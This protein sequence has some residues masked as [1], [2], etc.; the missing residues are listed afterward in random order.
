MANEST[1]AAILAFVNDIWEAAVL[2]ARENSVMAPLVNS[3][4][5]RVGLADRF[6]SRYTG[7]TIGALAETADLSS[8]TFTP[9][10]ISVLTPAQYGAQYYITDL[11][12]DSDPFSVRA[13][14]GRDLGQLLAVHVDT[15]LVGTFGSFTGGTIGT[16]GGTITWSNVAAGVSYLRR[17]KVAMP[18]YAI[19]EPG[20]WYHLAAA[21]AAGVTVTNM[22]ALQNAV[23]GAFYVG[24]AMGVNHYI[25][26]NIT[27]GTAATGAIFAREA[28]GLDTRRGFRLEPQRDASRGGGGWELNATMV[29]AYGVW[30][31]LAGVQAVGTSVFS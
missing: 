25:D 22:P 29:Y 21:V 31:P 6:Y 9:G 27:S 1:G 28:V 18:Y 4:G 30:N 24:S 15:N 20:Q 13:D 7:G 14:A 26:A 16:A 23:S 2:V 10:T 8:Q 3:Y 5:D 19:W 12:V 17:Q 11:R